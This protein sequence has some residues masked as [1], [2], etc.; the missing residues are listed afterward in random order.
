[1]CE[2]FT[3]GAGAAAGSATAAGTAA[4]LAATTTTATALGTAVTAPT[5]VTAAAGAA[6]QAGY[7]VTVMDILGVGGVLLSGAG[8]Y[9]QSQ[10]TQ[11]NAEYQAAVA[12]NNQIIA[13]QQADDAIARGQ[14]AEEDHRRKVRQVLGAQKASLA[15]T[16]VALEDE[17]SA[18][19]VLQDTAQF[20]ELDS[21]QIRANAAREAYGYRAQAGNFG[22]ESQLQLARAASEA[23]NTPLLLGSTFISGAATVGDRWARRNYYRR[24]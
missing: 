21:L 22:G 23:S 2:L 3:I 6:A 20:G 12:R 9:N 11:A 1:M 8:M 10:A 24:A 16:G 17:T 4:S 18:S 5:Y 13:N 14:Q 15:G 7:A 19:N